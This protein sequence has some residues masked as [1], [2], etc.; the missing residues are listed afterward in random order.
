MKKNPSP[1]DKKHWVGVSPWIIIGA[2]LVLVPIFIFMTQQSLNRQRAY[3][4]KLLVEKGA[5]L[6]RSFE[7]GARTG[8]GLQWGHFQV[9]KLLMETAQQS[10]IDYL[11][12][13]DVK[14][15]ILADSDP[16]MIGEIYGTNL[17]LR[18]IAASENLQWRQVANTE[19]ADTFEVFRQFRPVREDDREFRGRIRPDQVLPSQR[20]KGASL[21][22]GLV[23]F[24]GLDMGP[25]EAARKEDNRHTV[26]M[27]VIFLLIGVSGV[28]SLMLAQGYRSARTSLSRVQAFSDN[29]VENMPM[30]LLA[31][32]GD[33][34]ITAFNQTAETIL[35]RSASGVVG[36]KAVDILPDPC[37]DLFRALELEKRVIEREIDCP[38]ADGRTVPLEVI[39]TVL[40]GEKGAREGVVLF[41]DITEIRQLKN[42]VARSQR[43]ASLGSLAAGVAHEIRNPLS[44]IKGFATYFKERYRNSPE[45]GKTADIM[46]QE[47]DRLN[48]VIGQL[49]DYARPMTMNRQEAPVQMVVRHALRLMEGEA[50]EKGVAIETDLPEGMAP[51][52]ID[53]DRMKQVFINLYLN[54]LSAMEK[55][56][57]LTVLSAEQPDRRVRVDV[58]DTG[59][60]IDPQDMGRIFDPYF[61]TKPSG[62][63]L[64]LAIVQKIVEAH[65]GEIRVA[66]TPGQ[67]TTV[68]ILLPL[69]EGGA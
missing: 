37:R 19:G 51:V 43:L 35:D 58:R 2:V 40:E 27:A 28:I 20:E 26:M 56:G 9:Q 13:T 53:S 54:A 23:I 34:R 46:I 42:E 52:S 48:R 65:G 24:V 18:S 41:R 47:V 6:I 57:T 32:D 55:G 68:S 10:G 7:A 49:L 21:T 14:G 33:G 60:G 61:T 69:P 15:V 36:Q 17:D 63:G 64:G 59:A 67:G 50:R 45:D 16:S 12:V 31:I 11:I 8:A 22:E 30:G 66:S 1:I 3:T 4:Q 39:A 38:L 44:S 62:A 5:A 25:V 29:L